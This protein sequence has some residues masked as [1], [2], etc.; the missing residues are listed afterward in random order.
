MR[1]LAVWDDKIY[2]GGKFETSGE[3]IVNNIAV[4]SGS[5]WQALGAGLNGKVTS[6]AAGQ[7]GI[8]AA[9]GFRH[10]GEVELNHVGYWDG[11]EWFTL[12]DG[13]N[14][15]VAALAVYNDET[16]HKELVYAAGNFQFAGAVSVS[17]IAVYDGTDWQALGSGLDGPATTLATDENSGQLFVAGNFTQAGGVPV[18]GVARWDGEEWF[19]VGDGLDSTISNLHFIDDDL[20]AVTPAGVY[21]LDGDS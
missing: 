5:N 12:G 19:A 10:S 3:N 6:L 15:E 13:L 2:A 4:F 9:G 16:H 14:D 8:Y 7:A 20:Y 17:R 1:A 18:A 11:D 21:R